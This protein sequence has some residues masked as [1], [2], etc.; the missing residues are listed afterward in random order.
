MAGA[1]ERA[2]ALITNGPYF[3][4]N[5]PFRAMSG[6]TGAESFHRLGLAG[7][8]QP[9]SVFRYLWYIDSPFVTIN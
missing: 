8:G 6:L 1:E 5:G 2:Q 7:N 4:V 9:P 3:V